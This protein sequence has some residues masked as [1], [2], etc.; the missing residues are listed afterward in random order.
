MG[1]R[2]PT[3][4][5]KFEDKKFA[6]HWLDEKVIYNSPE[7]LK[8]VLTHRLVTHLEI[9]AGTPAH[10]PLLA[11]RIGDSDYWRLTIIQPPL[12]I[13]QQ[14]LI[15]LWKHCT[16]IVSLD[17]DMIDPSPDLILDLTKIINL[18][19]YVS[20]FGYLLLKKNPDD[21]SLRTHQYPEEEQL[22]MAIGR[23]QY[24]RDVEI[25]LQQVG[26]LA[27]KIYKMGSIVDMRK[28]VLKRLGMNPN[29]LWRRRMR[30]ILSTLCVHDSPSDEGKDHQ[31]AADLPLDDLF[32]AFQLISE[33]CDTPPTF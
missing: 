6:K 31:L 26:T 16:N 2:A 29:R 12:E 27:K 15:I 7:H 11:R 4:S 3:I 19:R 32:V 28:P 24:L 8:T 1:N 20:S 23:N 21:Q 17:V 25:N 18:N 10:K 22:L 30:I 9:T 13:L 14:V 33:Y 5:I